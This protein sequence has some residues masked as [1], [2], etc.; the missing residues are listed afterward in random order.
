MTERPQIVMAI[1]NT[2]CCFARL[3]IQCDGIYK[4]PC[5]K[6]QE[7]LAAESLKSEKTPK[8]KAYD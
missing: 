4:C 6:R 5:G 1:R 8:S 7:R 2:K 3:L